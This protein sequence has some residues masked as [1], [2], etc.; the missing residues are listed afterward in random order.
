MRYPRILSIAA[1]PLLAAL[2]T[3]QTS[4]QGQQGGTTQQQGQ[5]L[6]KQGVTNQ[7]VTKQGVTNQGV[8]A[9]NVNKQSVT[10]Q[11]VNKEN[12][13]NQSVNKE[14]V[15]NQA[16]TKQGVATPT[17]VPQQP[18][19]P[20]NLYGNEGIVKLLGLNANQSNRLDLITKQTQ[21]R[22]LKEYNALS[23][24]NENER[25]IRQQELNNRYM[26]DWYKAAADIY[27]QRQL[28]RYRQLMYQNA[29]FSAFYDPEVQ[30]R[31]NL[32]EAQRND[33]RK[34]VEWSSQQMRNIEKTAAINR[35]QAQQDFDAYRRDYQD[36]FN[37]FLTPDQRRAWTELTGE[38]YSFTLEFPKTRHQP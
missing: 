15:T 20:P 8:N 4:T 3:S 25:F 13:N 32:T 29:G 19:Y 5:G 6:T 7:G 2:A 37:T 10:N 35:Q 38:P 31:L 34:T 18:A 22:Y 17:Q 24:L 28:A 11:G 36:R 14:N 12:V 21:E 23:S 9:E 26:S 16:V 27:D 1:I 33:L 30:A